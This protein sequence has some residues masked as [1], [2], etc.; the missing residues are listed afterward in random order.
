MAELGWTP[1]TL[2]SLGRLYVNQAGEA[3]LPD[4]Q[5]QIRQMT[6]KERSILEESGVSG[7]ER[8]NMLIERCSKLP[9]GIT[10]EELL[11][12]DRLAILLALRALTFGGM[13]NFN[14]S[15]QSCG[16]GNKSKIDIMEE[17]NEDTPDKIARKLLD[18]G[19]IEHED[20]FEMKEPFSLQLHDAKT[21]DGQSIKVGL[22]LL[23]GKDE[24]RVAR[25]MKRAQ[26]KN[27]PGVDSTLNYRLS[28]QIVTINGEVPP[29]RVKEE[30]IDTL[31]YRDS[32]LIDNF[33]TERE[34]GIDMGVYLECS[35]CGAGNEMNLPMTAEFFRPTDL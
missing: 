20:D 18:A 7:P 22:R 26:A 23:R 12:S 25:H 10:H 1:I 15:C 21:A 3:L 32:V 27:A 33:L 30:L 2:P 19:R 8:V 11:A 34:T 29:G 24:T 14:W 13:Y 6:T 4:G 17:L 16:A 31:S 28:L 5:V 9:Q 35:K